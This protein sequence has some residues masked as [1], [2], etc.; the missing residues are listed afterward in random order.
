MRK[1]APH[2]IVIAGAGTGKTTTVVEGLKYALGKQP[3]I[4]PSEQQMAIWGVLKKGF[5]KYQPKRVL[6]VAY[7]KDIVKEIEGRVQGMAEAKTAHSLGF[8]FI[9]N[10]C[11]SNKKPSPRVDNK[12][13][14][15][16]L[17]ELMN[18]D[19]WE[20]PKKHPGLANSVCKLVSLCKQTLTIPE[21]NNLRDLACH[22]NVEMEDVNEDLVY[23]Y[24]EKVYD[25]SL[26]ISDV[27]DF[28]D[29][30]WLPIQAKLLKTTY[31]IGIVDEAQDLN[32]ARQ[33]L[34]IK[35]CDRI[36]VVGDP[37]Q[38]IYG[39]TGA[40]PMSIETM[41]NRLLEEGKREVVILP[42]NMTRRCGKKIVERANTIVKDFFAHPS[43]ADG[44][45]SEVNTSQYRKSLLVGDMVICRNNAPLVKEC[46][47]LLSSGK[48]AR[49]IGRD[50]VEKLEK[51]A[52]NVLNG[53]TSFPEAVKAIHNWAENEIRKESLKPY[54]SESVLESIEDKRKCLLLFLNKLSVDS[55]NGKPVYDMLIMKSTRYLLRLITNSNSLDL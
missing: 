25:R 24:V 50:I 33:E 40:D 15:K 39:F 31:D 2:L 38:A 32:R 44:L 14:Y 12:R 18:L 26:E 47:S 21:V 48:P 13:S 8:S 6:F 20:L 16:I 43:N 46:L 10:Y 1:Q 34:V 30:I 51:I 17:A 19:L 28:D 36:V 4:E 55:C 7:N 23:S 42:L 27:V 54:P 3:A 45:V 9:T 52:K 53:V 37:N 5:S 41:K 11:R 35:T 29:M 49:I 22:Y